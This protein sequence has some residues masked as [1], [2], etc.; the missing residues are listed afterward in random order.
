MIYVNEIVTAVP[1]LH[2][3]QEKVVEMGR[4]ILRGKIPFVDQ[5]L[6]LFRNAGVDMRYLVRDVD[7]ILANP[8]LE[9]RNQV[10]LEWSKALAVQLLDKLLAQTGL[11]ANT[12]DVL[13]TT[14]CTGFMIPAVDAH[15]INHFRLR[16]DIVRMPFTELGCAA[17]AMSLSRARDYVLAH[18][19]ANVVVIA[20]ELPSLTYQNDDHR[21][22][23]LV[24]AA[25]FGDGGA[26]AL[27]SGKEAPCQLIA[28][29]TH[30]FYDSEHFMGFDLKS[31][32]FQIIL[33]RDIPKLIQSGFAEVTAGFLEPQGLNCRD[34]KTWVFHPGGR[35]IMDTLR[36]VLEL[37]ESQLAHSRSVLRKVGNLS[38]ASILWVLRETLRHPYESGPAV[39]AAFGP[40][41]NAELILADLRV[42]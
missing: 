37:D 41:F 16:Q 30:F 2:L 38:S 36:D 14:S 8:D 33:D 6:G 34:I 26:A 28:N 18:P 40:G 22:A 35:R 15:V 10:Y 3:D 19:Q 21:V 39:M 11:A 23:N 7:E 42:R 12:I 13:I 27:I 5:A 32:G 17:G 9:W 29:R 25:L 24:S 4:R 20:V 31:T 1:P